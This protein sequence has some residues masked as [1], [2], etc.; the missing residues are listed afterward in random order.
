MCKDVAGSHLGS[1]SVQAQPPAGGWPSGVDGRPTTIDGGTRVRVRVLVRVRVHAVRGGEEE[2]HHCLACPAR[3]SPSKS[4]FQMRTPPCPLGSGAVRLE[5]PLSASKRAR[6][7]RP[8]ATTAT[9][10]VPVAVLH[11][12]L[13]IAALASA[14]VAAM[15][16]IAGCNSS[17]LSPSSGSGGACPAACCGRCCSQPCSSRV[18]FLFVAF[19]SAILEVFMMA[20]AIGQRARLMPCR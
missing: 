3:C 5:A 10:N 6:L 20:A 18:Y 16:I 15:L 12:S 2:P 19:L 17:R 4:I 1:E 7:C 14:L 13:A 11:P 9:T 8:T